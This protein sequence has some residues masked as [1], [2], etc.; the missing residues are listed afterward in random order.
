MLGRSSEEL[1]YNHSRGLRD[2]SAKGKPVAPHAALLHVQEQGRTASTSRSRGGAAVVE[3][4][5]K[6]GGSLDPSGNRTLVVAATKRSTNPYTNESFLDK[7]WT[8]SCYLYAIK[9][10][11][12]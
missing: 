11:A 1:F 6:K 4:L 9:L 8:F 7:P 3:L 5:E 2:V 10:P 12:H